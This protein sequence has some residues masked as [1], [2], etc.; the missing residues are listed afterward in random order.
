MLENNDELVNHIA[1][2][3]YTSQHTYSRGN[4]CEPR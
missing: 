3:R 4:E 1:M 2:Q